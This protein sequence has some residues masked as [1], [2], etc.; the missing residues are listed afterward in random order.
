VALPP[1][2]KAR[3]RHFA[4][5]NGNLA[6]AYRVQRGFLMPEEIVAIAGSRLTEP[7]VWSDSLD[8]VNRIQGA[9]LG[10]GYPQGETALASV[11]RM[12]SRLYLTSQL[13]RDID[14]MSMA[15]GLEVR[16]PFVDDRLLATVWPDAGF[17][18]ARLRG[19]RLLC[20]AL[21]RPLPAAI[22]SRPKQGFTLPFDRWMRG[23]LGP[24]VR[25]GLDRLASEGWIRPDAPERVWS[26]WLARETHWSRP[27]G[28]GV[29]GS[30]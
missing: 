1:R 17:Y 7:S 5:A 16:V 12:E 20:E 27:W 19:K 3:W 11:A 6:E 28:L 18:P 14:A 24:F 26:S 22:V 25:E 8:A 4:H 21:E 15:H 29:L 2:L 9:L 10:D 13:L 30:F 23:E